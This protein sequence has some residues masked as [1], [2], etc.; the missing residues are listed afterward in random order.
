MDVTTLEQSLL[1]DR[2]AR[3]IKAGC[4]RCLGTGMAQS[5]MALLPNCGK[6]D[7]VGKIKLY[8]NGVSDWLTRN[9][10]KQVFIAFDAAPSIV[11]YTPTLTILQ[12]LNL[13]EEAGWRFVWESDGYLGNA[14][15]SATNYQPTYTD[16]CQDLPWDQWLHDDTASELLALVLK[17]IEEGA[18]DGK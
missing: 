5:S 18:R 1:L 3:E 12:A 17:E 16:R 9:K 8:P 7:G 13:L 11:G 14:K 15:W 2:I 10:R 6:C 4:D